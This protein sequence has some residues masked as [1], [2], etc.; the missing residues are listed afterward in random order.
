[1]KEDFPQNER[2]G[3]PIERSEEKEGKV[4]SEYIKIL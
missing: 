4:S 2:K 3:I 1:M